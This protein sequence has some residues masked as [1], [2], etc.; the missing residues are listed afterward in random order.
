MLDKIAAVH[1]KPSHYFPDTHIMTVIYKD[2]SIQTPIIQMT[3]GDIAKLTAAL[4]KSQGWTLNE[5]P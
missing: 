4:I 1:V 5:N 3:K 2:G